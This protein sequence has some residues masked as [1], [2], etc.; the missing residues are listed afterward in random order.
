[1]NDP[2]NR[3][4]PSGLKNCPKVPLA[5][6]GANIKK[7]IAEAKKHAKDNIFKKLK[8][9]YDQVKNGGPWDYK[10]AGDTSQG[11]SEY[12]EFGNFNYGATGKAAGIPDA[13]VAW[14]AGAAQ[15]AGGTSKP[16]WFAPYGIN[17]NPGTTP[18]L[19]FPYGDDPNDQLDVY[20]GMAYAEEDCGCP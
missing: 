10:W 13:L 15:V 9:F 17:N 3:I 20:D 14:A 8:W 11:N 1:M 19:T 5:P 4:D 2:I 7:N 12:Q 6:K 18:M 16:E